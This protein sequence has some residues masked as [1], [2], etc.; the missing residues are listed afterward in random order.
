MCREDVIFVEGTVVAV[1]NGR[2]CRVRL[3]NGHEMTGFLVRD[4]AVR[5]EVPAPGSKL[6][7]KVK[8][9]DLSRGKIVIEEEK[10]ESSPIS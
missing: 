5:A 7:L 9:Y 8:P 1:R 4:D 10:N 6:N 2:V 3:A